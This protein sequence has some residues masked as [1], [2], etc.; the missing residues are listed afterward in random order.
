MDFHLTISCN[1]NLLCIHQGVRTFQFLG[2]PK[3]VNIQKKFSG[4]PLGTGIYDASF[5]RHMLVDFCSRICKS[6]SLSA[7]NMVT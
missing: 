3:T 5:V 7:V 6:S 1:S 4:G 2:N